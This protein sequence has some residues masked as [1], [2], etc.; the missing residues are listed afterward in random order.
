MTSRSVTI[1]SEGTRLAGDLYEPPNLSAGERR[2]AIVVCH[3]WGQN[4][5]QPPFRRHCE[6]F[7]AAGYVALAFDFRGWGQSDGKV[8][9]KEPLPQERAEV[10][11]RVQVIR[12]LVD[13]FD[14]TWDVR[15][16]IDFLSGEPAV[17]V[18]RMGLWATS[19]AGGVATWTAAH[20]PRVKCV[21]SQVGVQD[22]REYFVGE[23]LDEARR[24]AVQE[25][26]GEVDPVPQ[27][28]GDVPYL[29]GTPLR[30]KLPLWS[31]IAYSE[32]LRVPLML[33]DAEHEPLFDRRLNG[34]RMF[35]RVRAAGKAPVEYHL[36]A[37]ARHSQ[38]YN[39]RWQEASDL[40]IGWFDRHLAGNR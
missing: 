4:K 19:F 38:V 24:A 25:A 16:A 40:A 14:W 30:S 8:V 26:R 27:G 12:D 31:P 36:L 17:D 39:E 35:E 11:V 34:E 15:H 6:A 21:V 37:G 29:Q 28:V 32:E 18:E 20:D 3:G 1:W 22:R 10:T 5:G 23:L 7:A 2:P 9:V 33:I 13:P